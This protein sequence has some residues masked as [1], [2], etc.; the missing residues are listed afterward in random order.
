MY[1]RMMMGK[2]KVTSDCGAEVR[3]KDQQGCLKGRGRDEKAGKGGGEGIKG[4]TT[5]MREGTRVS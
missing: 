5:L 3:N 2:S 4:R 1:V